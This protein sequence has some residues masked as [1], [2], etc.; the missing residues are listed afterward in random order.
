M[1]YQVGLASSGF[2]TEEEEGR[3]V[4]KR[5]VRWEDPLPLAFEGG[6]GATTEDC[7]DL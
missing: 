5:D 3:G 4:G 7:S 1:D 2:L 6:G